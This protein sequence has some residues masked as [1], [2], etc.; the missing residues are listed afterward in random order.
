MKLATIKNDIAFRKIF[1][2]EGKSF[3]LISFLNAVLQLEGDRRVKSIQYEN[4]FSFPRIMGEKGIIMDVRAT[5]ESGRIFII[6]MQVAEAD[7]FDKRVQYYASREY[8]MQIKSGESYKLLHPTVF[9]G[10]LDFS[11][12]KGE[13]YLSYHSL[14]DEKTYE[15]KLQDLRFAFIEL[16]KF[17]KSESELNSLIDQWTYFLKN[18][19]RLEAIPASLSD[20]G[21]KQAYVDLDRHRWT[22]K[23]LKDYED[24]IMRRHDW[25]GALSLAEKRGKSAGIEEGKKVGI[26]EGQ[27]QEKLKIARAMKDMGLPIATIAEATGLD[28]A[29]LE[30][31]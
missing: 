9:I 17:N 13:D 10:I 20:T 8:S 28:T 24:A 14:L 4:P 3:I 12:F 2:N 7:G 18:S 19:E 31:F 27:L 5:D 22:A 23:D 29:T 1:G 11:Y 26:E 16:P 30:G 15:R 25:E 6:E 21:L